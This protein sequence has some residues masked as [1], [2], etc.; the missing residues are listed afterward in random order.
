MV[1][2]LQNTLEPTKT[3]LI[4]GAN[5]ST[6]E[7]FYE[8]ISTVLIP[9]IIWGR[10]LD[11]FVDILSGGFGTPDT[12]FILIWENSN[13]SRQ[14]LGYPETER[15]LRKRLDRCHKENVPAVETQLRYAQSNEGPTLFDWLVEIINDH[16]GDEPNA[17]G[18]VVLKLE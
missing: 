6:L 5:F 8:E 10:N 15:Q 13:I 1:N 2:S 14:R 16:S 9:G 18:Q 11:A 7:E 3:Y 17:A 4:D 12:G